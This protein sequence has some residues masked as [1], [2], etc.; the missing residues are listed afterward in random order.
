RREVDVGSVCERKRTKSCGLRPHMDPH[1][2]ETGI[3]KSFHLPLHQLRQRVAG[4][5]A[6][7]AEI[8]WYLH[9]GLRAPTVHDRGEAG[10]RLNNRIE[11]S[12]EQTRKEVALQDRATAK[13]HHSGSL[14]Q[15]VARHA[16]ARTQIGTISQPAKR[17]GAASAAPAW[18][19]CSI[20]SGV[21]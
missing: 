15:S 14:P 9:Y 10:T 20:E 16:A 21:T 11:E 6:E 2:V 19:Q 13:W 18:R 1:I 4:K 5:I 3:E 8:R 7:V 12:R 17:E